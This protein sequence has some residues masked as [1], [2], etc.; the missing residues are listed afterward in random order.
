MPLSFAA[1]DYLIFQLEAAFGL[2]RLLEIEDADG[3][4]IWHLAAY[5]EMF[6]DVDTAE[7]AIASGS[8]LSV[9]LPHTALTNRAF[10]STQVARLG[11]EKLNENELWALLEWKAA[12]DRPVVDRSIRLM[13]GLR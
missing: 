2:L 9:D 1:G 6:P 13:L 7:A 3:D 8:A 11:N 10:E 12:D 5:R 4:P